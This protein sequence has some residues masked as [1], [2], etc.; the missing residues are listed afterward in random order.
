MSKGKLANIAL[1]R[2]EQA[3]ERISPESNFF[4]AERRVCRSANSYLLANM[5]SPQK[6]LRLVNGSG[7]F[8]ISRARTSGL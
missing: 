2:S 8:C 5:R 3:K 7:V 1:T 4:Q 6:M